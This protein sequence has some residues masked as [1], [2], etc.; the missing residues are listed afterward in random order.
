MEYMLVDYFSVWG[1]PYSDDEGQ[2]SEG[3]WV[4]DSRVLYNV[5]IPEEFTDKD[6]I[7]VLKET[8]YLNT[9]D[10]SKFHIDYSCADWIEIYDS[11]D[12]YPLCSL[13]LIEEV[14]PNDT[15]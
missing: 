11:L 1:S 14:K 4:N 8:G 13:R 7:R 12:M 2:E 3:Y 6:I 5:T 9:N 15:I 10:T